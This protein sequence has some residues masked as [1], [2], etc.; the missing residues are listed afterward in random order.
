MA[1]TTGRLAVISYHSLEDRIVKQFFSELSEVYVSAGASGVHM[2]SCAGTPHRHEETD[3]GL[4]GRSR[5]QPAAG[6][7]SS[8]WQSACRWP[9][10]HDDRGRVMDCPHAGTMCH[11]AAYSLG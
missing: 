1:G 9:R 5:A 4:R 11:Q 3:L 8:E 7:R 6:A 10:P 2:R